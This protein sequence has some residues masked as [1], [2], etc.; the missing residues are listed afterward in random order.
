MNTVHCG[1]ALPLSQWSM[2]KLATPDDERDA[3]KHA[4]DWFALHAGQRMQAVNHF[5]VAFALIL[6]AYNAAFQAGNH[7]VAVGLALAGML[8]SVS[9]LLLELRTRQLV[10]VSEPALAALQHRLA[11]RSATPEL[12]FV[13]AADMPTQRFRKYSFVIRA[14]MCA[15]I[16]V[17]IVAA[18][19]ATVDG[20]KG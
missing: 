3:L 4:W 11:S 8:I 9:F 5:L 13:D 1:E 6:V 17:M 10:Q 19:A 20:L 18:V 12:T 7:L 14:L 2:S 15:A 16:V